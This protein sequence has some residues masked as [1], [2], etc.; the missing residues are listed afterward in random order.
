MST[1]RQLAAILFADIQGYTSLMQQDEVKALVLRDKF[2]KTLEQEI[3]LHGGRVAV[4][5]GDGALCVFKSATGA[6]NA[7]IAVQHKMFEEPSVP[8]RI[9]IHTGDVVTEG[10]NVY[11][12]GVNVASRIESFAVPGS[13]FISGK[14]ADEI[15]NQQHI[16]IVSLGNFELK[17]VSVPVEIFAIRNGN[18]TVPNK[19]MLIGKG[20]R[21]LVK[22][23]IG[24]KWLL[25]TAILLLITGGLVFLNKGKVSST[26]VSQPVRT[27][28][29]IPFAN[30]SSLKDDEYFADGMCDQILTSLSKISA[31]NILSRT[32]TLQYRDTKK[33][34]KEISQQTGADI[35]LE[36]SVQKSG[37][38]IRINVQLID[39]IHDKHLWAETYDRQL[40]D[41][42]TVQSEIAEQIS[43]AMNTTLTDAEKNLF[44]EK[45]TENMAAFDLF[46]RGNKL[47][48]EFWD[49][50][51][52]DKVPETVSL[53]E[54]A[55]KLDP[56]FIYA[57]CELVGL[58]TEISFRKPVT[59]SEDYR[60]KA[61]EWLDK[62]SV[63][64]SDN[65]AIHDTKALYKYEGER[66]YAGALAELDLIDQYFHNDK[67][68]VSMRGY[69]LRRMGRLEEA[70]KYFIRSAKMYPK[71]AFLQIDVA[72]TYVLLRN[73]DSSIYYF[74]KAIRL[75][76]DQ[77]DFYSGKASVYSD[78][79]GDLDM[80]G[81]ILKDATTFADTTELG[82]D[83]IYQDMLRGNYAGAIQRL[84]NRKDSLY[85]LSQ[86]S[87]KPNSL[88][89]AILHNNEGKKAEA[90]IYFQKALETAERLVSRFPEDFRAHATLGAAYAGLGEREQALSEG[91]KS[92]SLMPIS[93][94]AIVGIGPLENLALIHLLLGDQ[95]E[96]IDIL[97]QLLKMPFGWDATNSKTLYKTHPNWKLLQKNARFQQLLR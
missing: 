14:V 34:M 10:K 32:S 36:G 91:T 6:V 74:D 16:S 46:L 86:A 51:R 92:R 60:K 49:R 88:I 61:K 8:L 42:F 85:S 28:A 38:K 2:Q 75:K 89:L 21:S 50:T 30:L 63:I 64:P 54:Q 43:D 95:D 45:P 82:M 55:I 1:S 84:M 24:L 5:S 18:L 12:D 4:F 81:R 48:S 29:V 47:S 70:L 79:I 39:A 27:I 56:N 72:S 15:K 90:K 17:N 68:T 22:K 3:R 58:Y 52:M 41:V 35:L 94:D 59:N 78:L 31:L 20:Q 53:Y 73:A 93:V 37:D 80:A 87:I 7:A 23:R 77:A 76:P 33:T 96:A 26:A 11:G 19:N 57:Y 9:G 62:L 40:K 69:V 44:S 71:Y 65:P 13:V 83:Y 25:G 67:Q 97:E 66:D